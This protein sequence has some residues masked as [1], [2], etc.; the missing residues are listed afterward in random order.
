MNREGLDRV[1]PDIAVGSYVAT[2]LLVIAG[3]LTSSLIPFSPLLAAIFHY[4]PPVLAVTAGTA[5]AVSP[6]P[7]MPHRLFWG[8]AAVFALGPALW[9]AGVDLNHAAGIVLR[10][11]YGAGML[12]GGGLWLRQRRVAP[13]ADAAAV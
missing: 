3:G 9:L 10:C 2:G 5:T 11:A 4:A 1:A 6:R 7:R 8:T 13:P 12:L